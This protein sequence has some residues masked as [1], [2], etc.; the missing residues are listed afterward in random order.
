MATGAARD[1]T[2]GLT[3]VV[4][5]SEAV[6]NVVVVAMRVT[7]SKGVVMSVTTGVA[8]RSAVGV[9]AVTV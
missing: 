1:V 8:T 6:D 7:V 5:L 2:V 4:T 3:T 9:A